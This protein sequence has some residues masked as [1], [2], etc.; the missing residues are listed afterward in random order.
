MPK[1]PRNEAC[2]GPQR[3][4]QALACQLANCVTSSKKN[5]FC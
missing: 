5:I 2:E 4:A 3:V 1:K